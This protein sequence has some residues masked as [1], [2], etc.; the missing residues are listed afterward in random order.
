MNSRWRM[1]AHA[2]GLYLITPDEADTARLLA[3]TAPLLAAG[4]TGC[5]TATRVPAASCGMSR[6]SHCK[7]FACGRRAP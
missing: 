4:T 1:P 2:R 7:R 5:N 3:R 6:P